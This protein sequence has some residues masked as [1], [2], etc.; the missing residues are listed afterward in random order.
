MP[1]GADPG[2]PG[3]APSG[4]LIRCPNCG[5]ANPPDRTFC[6]SC[7]SKL[8]DAGRVVA[9]T[10]E[11][12]ATAVNQGPVV[13]TPTPNDT[14]GEEDGSGSRT[15]MLIALC[16]VG[17]LLGVGVI[18]GYSLVRGGGG[19]A[20]GA[21]PNPSVAASGRAAPPVGHGRAH[22]LRAR[23]ADRRAHVLPEATAVELAINDVNA[24]SSAPNFPVS[25]V[26]DGDDQTAWKEGVR[27][28]GQGESITLRFDP[29]TVTAI[30]VS[31][32][33]SKD[34][35]SYPVNPRV[36]AINV[37]VNGRRADRIVLKDT[38]DRTTYELDRRSRAPRRSRSRSC[39]STPARTRAASR[40]G[41]RR[42]S[43]RSW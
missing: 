5:I 35:T 27:S 25:N 24:S 37:S 41:R 20:T 19:A 22:G 1:T 11:Q 33:F 36:K 28:E 4:A 38:P 42:P 26:D 43:A 34:E 3:P 17:V 13:R 7:G 2:T 30:V 21:S 29:A 16:V 12:I 15:K 18:A 8:A 31:N 14:S 9:A 39:P 32:G 40:R 23:G 10:P 6:Q